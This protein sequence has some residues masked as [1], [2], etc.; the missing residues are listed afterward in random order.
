[1]YIKPL[2]SIYPGD[3]IGEA[4]PA[5]AGGCSVQDT[6]CHGREQIQ[7]G[8]RWWKFLSTGIVK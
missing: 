5:G 4:F 7:D 2:V 3:R 6:S 1:M 8:S